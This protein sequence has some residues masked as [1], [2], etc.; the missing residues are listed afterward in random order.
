MTDTV[1][2]TAPATENIDVGELVTRAAKEAGV[3][4]APDATE[5]QI[6]RM[7][8][9]RHFHAYLMILQERYDLLISLREDCKSRDS[10]FERLKISR[11]MRGL[12]VQI[13]KAG[14]LWTGMAKG[15]LKPWI[16]QMAP[17]TAAKIAK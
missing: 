15:K 12:A 10:K 14:S 4:L 11:T 7:A 13:S 6:L 16:I 9:M 1:T 17:E 5:E 2:I 3:T 8:Y